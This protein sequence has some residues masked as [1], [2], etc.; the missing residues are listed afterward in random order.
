MEENSDSTNDLN[1]VSESGHK[2]MELIDC[3]IDKVVDGMKISNSIVMC[4]NRKHDYI[5]EGN[6]RKSLNLLLKCRN[7]L[8]CILQWPGEGSI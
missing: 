8:I 7:I 4:Q 5:R 6:I 2:K 3:H 1:V